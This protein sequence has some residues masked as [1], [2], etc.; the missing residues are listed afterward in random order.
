MKCFL[1]CIRKSIFFILTKIREAVLKAPIKD[2]GFSRVKIIMFYIKHI[3]KLTPRNDARFAIQKLS[4]IKTALL[5]IIFMR[6][7]FGIKNYSNISISKRD[8]GSYI[9]LINKINSLS[10]TQRQKIKF[11]TNA[12]EVLL[13]DAFYGRG[14][15]SKNI[16]FANIEKISEILELENSKTTQKYI[17]NCAKYIFN[18]SNVIPKLDEIDD[19]LNTFQ[20]VALE[21]VSLML[22]FISSSYLF[23]EKAREKYIQIFYSDNYKT[24]RSINN[25]F[26]SA[27]EM[28]NY[29]VLE[30]ALKM[31]NKT[32]KNQKR[33]RTLE[34]LYKLFTRQNYSTLFSKLSNED[35]IEF[36]KFIKNKSIAIVAPLPVETLSGS[37]IDSHDYVLRIGATKHPVHLKPEIYGSRTDIASI[38]INDIHG[39]KVMKNEKIDFS[40]ELKYIIFKNLD[41]TVLKNHKFKIPVV[42]KRSIQGSAYTLNGFLNHVPELVLFLLGSGASKVSLFSMNFFM[43]SSPYDKNYR[44]SPTAH[45]LYFAGDSLASSHIYLKKLY[46]LGLLEC[47][48]NAL[49]VIKLSTKEYLAN[50]E[51]IYKDT[52]RKND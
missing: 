4:L 15:D 1:N 18:I 34:Y 47:D 48:E 23:K 19:K 17:L 14:A 31:A 9:D 40:S 43:A 32:I 51:N 49:K 12:I 39:S 46:D 2:K 44:N 13:Y 20:L 45:N 3:D 37:L 33:A 42:K 27:L 21:R 22:G 8:W 41:S 25:T 35:E 16:A 30:D 38:N 7:T 52:I 10:L 26:F 28:D 29:D 24:T 11:T 6:I 36:S 50:M 5:K